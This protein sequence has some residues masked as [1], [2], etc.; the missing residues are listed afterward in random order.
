MPSAQ[1]RSTKKQTRIAIPYMQLE[2]ACTLK[3]RNLLQF[4]GWP[5][6]GLWKEIGG[7]LCFKDPWQDD[8]DFNL[9]AKR[10]VERSWCSLEQ[11]HEGHRKSATLHIPSLK[12][13]S[14]P[15]LQPN[16]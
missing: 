12:K 11:G 13:R 1:R 9:A 5:S 4:S 8:A 2:Y 3:D 7:D 15:R 6:S 14:S 10:V 16:K